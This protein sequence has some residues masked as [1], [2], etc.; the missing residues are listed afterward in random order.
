MAGVMGHHCLRFWRVAAAA[1]GFAGASG[2]APAAEWT[3]YLGG[4]GRACYSPLDQITAG[5]VSRL[6]VAWEF[7]SGDPGQ[8][9]CNPIV[10]GGVLFGTT[11]TNQVFALDAA[12]GRERWRFKE[13]GHEFGSN[14]RGVAYW[15]DGDDRRILF[16]IDAWLYAVDAGTGKPIPTF[17][18][19][20]KVSL[21]TGLGDRAQDKW[22]VCTSPGTVFENLIVMP[23][24]VGELGDSAPGHVQAFDVRTGKLAWTFR[25]IPEP[26]EF[27]YDTWPKDAYRNIDVGGANCWTGMAIDRSR[28]IL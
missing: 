26:G 23:T 10:V 12:T 5:N 15:A 24:R 3:E 11:A 16:N 4:P 6:Q 28:G 14:Q 22:V 27:G 7:H 2:V 19:D 20:G 18:T 13:P 8:T 25:T 17:G 9:Q 1:L 21:K